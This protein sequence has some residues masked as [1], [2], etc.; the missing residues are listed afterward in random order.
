MGLVRRRLCCSVKAA[1]RVKTSAV[2]YMIVSAAIAIFG[3]NV[4]AIWQGVVGIVGSLEGYYGA[5]MLDVRR[6]RLFLLTLLV[7]LSVSFALGILALNQSSLLLDC[8]EGIVTYV[9][10]NITVTEGSEN[11]SGIEACSLSYQLYGY[12]ELLGGAALGL[13]LFFVTSASYRE[14]VQESVV[15]KQM[16]AEQEHFVIAQS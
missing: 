12:F 13:L 5:S 9:R 4:P 8:Q 1:N 16:I 3:R 7:C 14:I 10:E 2:T 11:L 15:Y 6:V